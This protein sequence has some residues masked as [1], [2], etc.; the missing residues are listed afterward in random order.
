MNL[1]IIAFNKLVHIGV[2]QLATS[3]YVTVI[4][5]QRLIKHNNL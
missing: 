3:N 1:A 4:F 5:S 2:K